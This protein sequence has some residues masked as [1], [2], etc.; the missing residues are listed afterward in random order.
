MKRF[1]HRIQSSDKR[2]VQYS[3]HNTRLFPLSSVASSARGT[4]NSVSESDGVSEGVGPQQTLLFCLFEGPRRA[5]D[6]FVMFWI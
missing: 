2:P 4:A 6:A 1:A 5:F 3:T